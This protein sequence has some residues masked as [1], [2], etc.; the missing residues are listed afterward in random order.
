MTSPQ[1]LRL[2]RI[3]ASEAAARTSL[4][5]AASGFDVSGVGGGLTFS[6]VPLN[7]CA[8]QGAGF[9]DTRYVRWSGAQFSISGT[10]A[11]SRYLAVQAFGAVASDPP[12]ALQTLALEGFLS[13][14]VQK[15]GLLGRGIPE[16]ST[17]ASTA[18]LP[19][20]YRWEIRPID[21]R[22]GTDAVIPTSMCGE[23]RCDSLGQLIAGGVAASR[24]GG[25]VPSGGLHAGDLRVRT[26][27]HVGNA[28]LPIN[29]LQG[30][31]PAD[32]ILVEDC[33]LRDGI[34]TLLVGNSHC[35]R[36]RLQNQQL[37]ILGGP[38]KIMNL[39]DQPGEAMFA[40]DDTS[41]DFDLD[42]DI[43]VDAE[44]PSLDELPVTLTFDVGQRH[45]TV[46]QAFDLAAGTVLDLGRPLARA[47]S[48]R[49]A[50][51]RIGEGELVE[52]DGRIGV[53]ITRIVSRSEEAS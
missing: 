11:L 37:V 38:T 35:W 22:A 26:R 27:L 4:A 53:S 34:M 48:I 14:L 46:A 29:V 42:D 18:P 16:F 52:I 2:A 10:Q 39:T 24:L 49:S 28:R 9:D 40:D 45:M 8:N 17:E 15:A 21:E 32:V 36:V 31:R 23:L 7:F 20:A 5:A 19:F 47:V 13:D 41:G 3:S 25:D 50:G 1:P 6:L 51:V 33:T 43:D 12:Q 44:P 30:L